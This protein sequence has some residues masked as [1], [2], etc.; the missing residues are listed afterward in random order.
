MEWSADASPDHRTRKQLIY[1]CGGNSSGKGNKI[2]EKKKSCTWYL[3]EEGVRVFAEGR[4]HG[5]V[6]TGLAVAG[7]QLG[8]CV[9]TT[10]VVVVLDIQVDQLGEIDAQRAARI[11]DVLAVKRL[12][13]RSGEEK[14]EEEQI[15]FFFMQISVVTFY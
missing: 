15:V 6:D 2:I 10:L 8:S 9:V 5:G 1:E 14:Q 12:D 4:C 3:T 7:G 13:E 11:V